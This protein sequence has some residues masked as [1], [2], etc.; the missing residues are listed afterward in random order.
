MEKTSP[1]QLFSNERRKAIIARA[2]KINKD[3]AGFLAELASEVI[4]ERL[5]VVNRQFDNAL[6]LFSLFGH[7]QEK[8]SNAPNVKNI[9]AFGDLLAVGRYDDQFQSQN[10]SW[11]EQKGI[12]ID[13]ESQN[14]ITSIFGLH[15]MNDLPGMLSQIRRSLAPDGLFLAA[16]PGDQTLKELRECIIAAESE[17]T[18]NVSL[19]IE[20]FGEVRQYGNLLQRAG[21]A[22]PVVDSEHY[23]IRYSSLKSL[24]GDLRAMAATR[25]L[26]SKQPYAS[27]KLFKRCEEIYFE[28]FSDADGKIRVTAEIVFLSGWAPHASQQKPLK[29]GSA[30]ASL[31][32]FLEK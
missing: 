20:P 24:A 21:F 3:D 9:A 32:D 1:K 15:W 13:P 8:L 2:R 27:R 16:L 17:L 30:K 10:Q 22:L 23:T 12:P 14:L 31:S 7:M 28:R 4:A 19:R 26:A 18:G 29:P 25:S 11:D 5:S 6:D